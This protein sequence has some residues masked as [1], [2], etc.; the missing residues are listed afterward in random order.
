MVSL[1]YLSPLRSEL[2]LKVLL[3][4]LGRERKIA[5][6]RASLETR[7]TTILHILEEFDDLNLTTKEQGVYRLSSLGLIEARI[8]KEVISTSE[9]IEKFKDFWLSHNVADIPPHL[10]LNLGALSNAS[11]VCAE[12]AELG[13]V[14]NTFLENIKTSKRIKGISPIFHR[15][16]TSLFGQL[17]EQGCTIEL[18][19]SGSVLKKI[20]DSVDLESVKKYLV[21]E[22]LKIFLR[23]DVKIALALTESSFSLG[24][25]GLSGMYDDTMDLLSTSA[26]AIEWGEHLFEE[27]VK[28]SK[29]IGLEPLV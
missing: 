16:F 5:D 3:S 27:V 23:D 14:H 9:V 25:F 2:K 10:L 12:A 29:R 13:V 26:Q 6:L 11:L 15:D 1:D 19:V 4:L 24:L 22:A 7:D 17:L 18:I 28:N 20:M 8:F 21:T